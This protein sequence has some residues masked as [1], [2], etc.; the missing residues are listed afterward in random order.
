[1]TRVAGVHGDRGEGFVELHSFA[2]GGSGSLLEQANVDEQPPDVVA[3]EGRHL[4]QDAGRV[5]DRDGGRPGGRLD[6]GLKEAEG[7]LEPVGRPAH[8]N[9]AQPALD[10]PEAF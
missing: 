5:A 8:Q 9:R 4:P 6:Q 10:S 2:G 7:R 3:A 1:M